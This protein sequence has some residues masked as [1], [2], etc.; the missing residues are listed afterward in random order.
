M[1]E[2]AKKPQ[3]ILLDMV[4]PSVELLVRATGA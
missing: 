1:I 4:A 2:A 3:A